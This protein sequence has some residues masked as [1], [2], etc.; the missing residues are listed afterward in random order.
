MAAMPREADLLTLWRL[1]RSF[2]YR[3]FTVYK[4]T[5]REY[6]GKINKQADVIASALQSLRLTGEDR[7]ASK[8]HTDK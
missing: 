1:P 8:G 2:G 6:E 4:A 5:S 3:V 7:H